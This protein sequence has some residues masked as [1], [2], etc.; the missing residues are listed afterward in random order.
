MNQP[1]TNVSLKSKT[2]IMRELWLPLMGEL[3]EASDGHDYTAD[4]L[5]E[6]FALGMAMVLDNDTHIITPRDQRLALDTAKSHVTRW[7]RLLGEVQKGGAATFL[8]Q[9]SKYNPALGIGVA[10]RVVN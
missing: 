9:C 4:D 1:K 6:F 8:E 3:S 10:S 7:V 2:D 5:L